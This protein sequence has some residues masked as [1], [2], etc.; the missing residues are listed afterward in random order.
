MKEER[1][2]KKKGEGMREDEADVHEEENKEDLREEEQRRRPTM[3]HRGSGHG[4]A[5]ST[6]VICFCSFPRHM[7]S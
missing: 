3:Q 7:I 1:K 6:C 2:E 5:H 4:G